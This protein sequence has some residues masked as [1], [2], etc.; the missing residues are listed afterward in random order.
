MRKIFDR[1]LTQVFSR[2]TFPPGIG[3]IIIYHIV[4]SYSFAYFNE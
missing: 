4:F 1:I 3:R 2:V